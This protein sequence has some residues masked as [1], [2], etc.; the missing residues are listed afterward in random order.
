M[1]SNNKELLQLKKLFNETKLKHD[2]TENFSYRFDYRSGKLILSYY[3]PNLV[4]ENGVLKTKVK[5]VE[6]YRSNIDKTNFK[7]YFKGKTSIVLD[8]AKFVR[9]EIE[10]FSNQNYIGDEHDFKW[11]VESFLSREFGQTKHIKPLSKATLKSY[12]NHLYQY[13]PF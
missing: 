12:K 1:K 2:I 5:K 6:K 13:F 8:D 9:D 3:V 11:W 7:K 10:R 4:R